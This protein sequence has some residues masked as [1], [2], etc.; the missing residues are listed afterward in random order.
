MLDNIYTTDWFGRKNN[1]TANVKSRLNW[2]LSGKPY[3]TFLY[4]KYKLKEL[5]ENEGALTN[6]LQTIV[7]ALDIYASLNIIHDVDTAQTD[8]SI[9]EVTDTLKNKWDEIGRAHV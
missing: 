8:G 6:E 3:S 7:E 2:K 9:I 4:D 5:I 1:T